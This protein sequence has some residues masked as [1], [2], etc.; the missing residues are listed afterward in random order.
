MNLSENS[1]TTL[2]LLEPEDA[3]VRIFSGN[4]TTQRVL[5]ENIKL[6]FYYYCFTIKII[7]NVIILSRV[8]INNQKRVDRTIHLANTSVDLQ[9]SID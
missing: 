4:N 6:A 1:F 5:N 7:L 3:Q 2:S 9:E 8:I